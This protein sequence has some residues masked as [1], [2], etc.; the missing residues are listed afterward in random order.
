MIRMK[1]FRD[2]P[3]FTLVEL[4]VV[5]AI[6]AVIATVGFLG[7]ANYRS[8]K[9]LDFTI[10]EIAAALRAT[11]ERAITQENGKAWGIRFTNSTSGVQSY[12]VFSGTVF[13]PSGVDKTYGLRRG[14]RFTDPVAS[15]TKDLF[16]QAISGKPSAYFS[17][18][19]KGDT[20]QI[21]NI[22]VATSGVIS[23]Q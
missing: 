16:F 20:T 17:I 23:I 5:V 10:N 9:N 6:M 13:A 7:L 22:I 15:S 14:T 3:G 19:L 4:L 18:T 1:R 21:K 11:Q 8:G 12:T 2:R